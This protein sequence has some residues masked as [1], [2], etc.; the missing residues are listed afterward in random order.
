VLGCVVFVGIPTFISLIP[1]AGLLAL[2]VQV[3]LVAYYAVFLHSMLRA[4]MAGRDDFPG[5]PEHAGVQDLGGEIFALAGPYVIS[6]LPL[7]A[8]RCAYADFGALGARAWGTA[9]FF[10]SGPLPYSLPQTPPWF[11]PLSWMLA[12]LGI[13]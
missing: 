4:S 10:L 7:I 8:L 13:L 1:F 3:F 2:I 12:G 6:F 11:V 9:G 5:W